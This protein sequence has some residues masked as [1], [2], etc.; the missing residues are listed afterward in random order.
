MKT[1]LAQKN[2]EN[3]K[4]FNHEIH[5]P[6]EIKSAKPPD[7]TEEWG[8]VN[9]FPLSPIPLSEFPPALG[10]SIARSASPASEKNNAPL[11][12][13]SSGRRTQALAGIQHHF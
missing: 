3:A 9:F 7:G 8:P 12:I 6:H 5:E 11:L 13:F 10:I 1:A 2:A 4:I